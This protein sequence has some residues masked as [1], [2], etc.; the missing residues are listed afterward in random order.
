[1][2]LI[3][4][5]LQKLKSN[6]NA[7]PSGPNGPAPEQGKAPLKPFIIRFRPILIGLVLVLA[8]GCGSV[9]AV[10]YL[11]ERVRGQENGRAIEQQRYGIRPHKGPPVPGSST[12]SQNNS[13]S[14]HMPSQ[15]VVRDAPGAQV[16]FYPPEQKKIGLAPVSAAQEQTLSAQPSKA[17]EWAHP[18]VSALPDASLSPRMT[19]LVVTPPAP[20]QPIFDA[21]MEAVERARRAALEKSARIGMLVNKI[22]QA[23]AGAP[24]AGN[25]QAL[26]AQ[27]AKIKGE[28]HSYV[29]KMRAYWNFQRGQ[30]PA[31][32]VD[33]KKVIALH[34]D[35]LEAG[36][37][38]ALIEIHDQRYDQAKSRLKHLRH[39][40]PE[41]SAV[42]DLI[43]R[44][45]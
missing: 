39:I 35:D 3:F 28:N 9:Y 33:L 8:L 16:Q 20:V 31:A 41:H 40:Y 37:N 24:N 10:Q 13:N 36:I 30:Y 14:L 45:K 18:K 2:S 4:Q 27:L 32:E 17:A 22:E 23:L 25:P 15:P 1:M 44:L 29:M 6:L 11:K 38:L 43:K 19:K 7:S 21:E 12:E 26:L 42:A 5:S 34:P